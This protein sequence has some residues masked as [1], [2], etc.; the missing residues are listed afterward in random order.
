M[1]ESTCQGIYECQ[2]DYIMTGMREVGI[3]SMN[4]MFKLENLKARG[5]KI[6]I[7][8]G[9]LRKDEGVLKYPPGNNYLSGITV[10][11]TCK[12]EYFIH[13]DQ[14]RTCVNG[15]WTQGWWVWCRSRTA[16]YALKWLTGI[17]VSLIF[18]LICAAIFFGCYTRRK[19]LNP[20]SNFPVN[21]SLA[22]S[23]PGVASPKGTRKSERT[24]VAEKPVQLSQP[25]TSIDSSGPN[26]RPKPPSSSG[27][28]YY[29][30]SRRI[31]SET[32]A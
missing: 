31:Y 28:V 23:K 4:V 30:H 1:V 16:E 5:S 14:Q 13:G 9:A 24:T 22:K 19:G 15:T 27:T 2:Y 17:S 7:S 3:N 8:C 25:S 26:I 20:D 11:F 29:S 12:P 6:W 21:R 32:S 10:T 18:V